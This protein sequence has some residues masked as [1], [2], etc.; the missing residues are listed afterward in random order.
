MFQTFSEDCEHEIKKYLGV[1]KHEIKILRSLSQIFIGTF[2]SQIR[3]QRMLF[4]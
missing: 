3:F 4:V 2:T 1:C